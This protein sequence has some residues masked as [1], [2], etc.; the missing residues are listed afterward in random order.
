MLYFRKTQITLTYINLNKFPEEIL[1][2]RVHLANQNFDNIMRQVKV[3][4]GPKSV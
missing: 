4:H 1:T 3:E 2:T